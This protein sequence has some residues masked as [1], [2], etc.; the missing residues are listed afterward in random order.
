M[1]PLSP[2]NYKTRP[3]NVKP[4]YS[5]AEWVGSIHRAHRFHVTSILS[6]WFRD[7]MVFHL[8]LGSREL[9]ASTILTFSMRRNI[10]ARIKYLAPTSLGTKHHIKSCPQKAGTDRGRILKRG[11][12]DYTGEPASEGYQDD[13]NRARSYKMRF[14]SWPCKALGNKYFNIRRFNGTLRL[15]SSFSK[16]L[17]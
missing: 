3:A 9:S 15:I 12:Q 4:S 17:L 10:Y 5:I 7:S 1:S 14:Q 8:T 11:V 13:C 16:E 2:R 6:Y